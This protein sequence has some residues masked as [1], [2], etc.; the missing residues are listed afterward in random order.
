VRLPDTESVKQNDYVVVAYQDGWYPGCVVEKKSSSFKISFMS[1]CRKPG[2]FAWPAREDIQEVNSE[3]ILDTSMVPECVSSGRQW[4]FKDCDPD[5]LD[6]ST[7]EY[8]NLVFA[9]F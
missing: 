5:Q 4:F 9:Y 8:V 3:F 7:Q 2:M 1:P 6:D